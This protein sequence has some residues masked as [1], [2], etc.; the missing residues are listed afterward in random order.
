[1]MR[2]IEFVWYLFWVGVLI[3]A[4]HVAEVRPW[5]ER[6]A[7]IIW[8]IL[9]GESIWFFALVFADAAWLARMMDFAQPFANSVRKSSTPNSISGV[10]SQR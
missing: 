3:A 7:L 1:M 5:A 9:I 2:T 6:F 4:L 8:P 10:G